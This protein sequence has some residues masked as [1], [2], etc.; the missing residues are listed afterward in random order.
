MARDGHIHIM[1]T[2]GAGKST[3]SNLLSGREGIK[4]LP[5][6]VTSNPYLDDFYKDPVRN[7]FPMQVF[8]MHARFKQA[9][10][11]E[12]KTCIMDMS[13]YGNDIFAGLMH[14]SGY[15]TEVDLNNYMAVS[16]SLKS[17][18]D[19]PAMVVYLKC[20]VDT[21]V[22]RIMKRGRASELN[23]PLSYWYDL[24]NAYEQWYENYN[25]SKKI[26]IDVADLDFLTDEADEDYI[27][28]IIMEEYQNA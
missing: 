14:N 4:L 12:G 16:D 21:A 7:A 8:L 28:D 26:M 27:L 13:I 9:K 24:N 1:G 17:M 11:N 22:K 3:L 5:E 25:D 2:V 15:M 19:K 18:L 23:A 10:E 20:S 6:P